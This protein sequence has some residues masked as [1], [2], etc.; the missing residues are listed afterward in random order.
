[1][2]LLPSLFLFAFISVLFSCSKPNLQPNTGIYDEGLIIV[3][4]PIDS[5]ISGYYENY[6]GWNESS[7]S[8]K[9]S[10]TFYFSGKVG[11][12]LGINIKSWYPGNP[13][14]KSIINGDLKLSDDLKSLSIRLESEHGGCWNVQHFADGEFV[15]FYF[16]KNTKWKD[17]RVVKSEKTYF[18]KEANDSSKRKAYVISGDVLKVVKVQNEW[19]L[20]EYKN[21]ISDKGTSGWVKAG[22][23]FSNKAPD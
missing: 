13:D 18:H 10:C 14:V 17:I 19:L 9:F 3:F 21:N 11:S 23:L 8:P 1:M 22:D 5:V 2:K 7:S 16:T 6:S 12:E 4:D 20:V 15:P